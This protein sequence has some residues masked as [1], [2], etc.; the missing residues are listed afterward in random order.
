[1]AYNF[2]NPYNFI[3]LD[4]KCIRTTNEE[5]GTYTGYME[6]ELETLTPLIML[7]TDSKDKEH[8]LTSKQE[9][10]KHRVYNETF[11]IDGRPAIP[12]SELRG[13]IRSKFEAL[14]SSCMSSIEQDLE[15]ACRYKNFN[16][17][18]PG[19][20]DIS[21]PKDVKLYKC[22][23]Y[24]VEDE[25]VLKYIKDKNLKSGDEIYFIPGDREATYFEKNKDGSTEKK[26]KIVHN[27]VKQ[28]V[29][30]ACNNAK[31]GILKLGEKGPKG[32]AI[33]IF[34][35]TEEEVEASNKSKFYKIFITGL[36]NTNNN[37]RKKQEEEKE[38]KEEKE[39]KKEHA[40][41]I[42][43]KKYLQP[44]WYGLSNDNVYFSLGQNGQTLYNNV[45]SDLLYKK[46]NEKDFRP[47]TNSNN[48]CEACRVF[49]FVSKDEASSGKVRVS[50]AIIKDEYNDASK[51]YA[52]KEPIVLQ[53]LASPRYTNL[54]F[55][56]T[57]QTSVDEYNNI[58]GRKEYWHHKPKDMMGYNN[59][60]KNNRNISVKPISE[61]IRYSFKVYF[62]NLT[63]EQLEHLN[64]AVSLGNTYDNKSNYA[65]KLGHGKPLGY[66]SVKVKVKDIQY[67]EI[68]KVNDRYTYCIKKYF[69]QFNKLFNAFDIDNNNTRYAM[70][71][72][73]DFNFIKDSTKVDYPRM[74]RNG[75]IFEWFGRDNVDK[76]K[77]LPFAN[78]DYDKIIQ[79]SIKRNSG[80]KH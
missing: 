59:V 55:Y 62:N 26:I 79:K 46:D 23:K 41:F 69:P 33:R 65:H 28:I 40:S 53:E 31:K 78:C 22:N 8:V 30:N 27:G 32:K 67:R 14:T 73:Y 47:C 15:F 77:N 5:C 38:Q 71:H 21:N 58:R 13:M 16:M 29:E 45:L 51:Y 2:I 35:N 36:T 56:M 39:K 80:K 64:M 44:V 61:G 72:M 17:N 70:M 68:K 50:D 11:K 63:K 76:K 6:C 37:I 49:G 43:E 4:K 12:G 10:D 9:E 25:K 19:L 57:K 52:T 24:V 60:E 7:D 34:E 18:I 3:P 20:L 48:L 66:G 42:G 74:K 54:N 75:D 1:M